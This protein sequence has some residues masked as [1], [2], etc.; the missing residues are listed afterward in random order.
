MNDNDLGQRLTDR[1]TRVE[2][3]QSFPDSMPRDAATLM[4]IDRTGTE[5]DLAAGVHPFEVHHVIGNT[6]SA[7][8]FCAMLWLPP[9]TRAARLEQEQTCSPL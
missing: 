5:L 2:R 7:Y 4:L 8:G 9:G 3:D 1:M 6:P